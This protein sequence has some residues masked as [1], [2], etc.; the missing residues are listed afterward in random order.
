MVNLRIVVED[1]GV[2]PRVHALAWAACRERASST[3]E[4]LHYSEGVDIVVVDAE[5][6]VG[7]VEMV[8]VL[9][10]VFDE[11]MSACV[12]GCGGFGDG[13]RGC[14]EEVGSSACERFRYTRVRW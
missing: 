14:G 2:Q 10:G 7:D 9:L 13:V 8:E 4:N 12:S 11:L 6:F 3:E 1:V 5:T